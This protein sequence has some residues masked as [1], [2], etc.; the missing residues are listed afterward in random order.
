MPDIRYL[1][2]GV[3]GVHVTL[4]LLRQLVGVSAN[5]SRRLGTTAN[6]FGKGKWTGR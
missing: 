5:L 6:G 4:E 1:R 3:V 2:S